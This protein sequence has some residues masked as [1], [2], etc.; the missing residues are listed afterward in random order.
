MKHQ[1]QFIGVQCPLWWTIDS[2]QIRCSAYSMLVSFLSW[3]LWDGYKAIR[4]FKNGSTLSHFG[5]LYIIS[6]FLFVFLTVDLREYKKKKSPM[7]QIKERTLMRTV[8]WKR[9]LK[10]IIRFTFPFG[11]TAKVLNK[12]V[13]NKS[14]KE[15]KELRVFSFHFL[16]RTVIALP[17]FT[18]VQIGAQDIFYWKDYFPPKYNKLF[19]SCIF[20][21]RNVLHILV[22]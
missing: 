4:S 17:A 5:H 8:Y 13:L 12:L 3:Y 10:S 6:K 19:T 16:W 15:V 18:S 20:M 2:C 9:H 1:E 22:W 11:A 7:K 21:Q 14:W